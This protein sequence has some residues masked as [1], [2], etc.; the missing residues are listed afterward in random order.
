MARVKTFINNGPMFPSDLNEIQ[1]DY[2]QAFSNY[3]LLC[4]RHGLVCPT[5]SAAGGYLDRAYDSTL[6][7]ALAG[8]AHNATCLIYIDP[9]D[10]DLPDGAARTGK[11]RH[12]CRLIT[13]ANTP[14][15][16]TS[17]V[18]DL[19]PV[20]T[21]ATT[22][23]SGANRQPIIAT[24]GAAVAGS[25]LTFANPAADSRLVQTGGDFNVPSAGF[26]VLGWTFTGASAS[27]PVASAI[28][29]AE[30]QYRQV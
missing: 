19:R 8:E 28:A 16:A 30:L 4:E 21:W 14:L 15:A 17:V 1:D 24:L 23:T 7:I 13:N 3:R 27:S 29:I 12:R 9:A 2:D 26:Y 20:A 22:A 6:P 5:A 18:F 25:V 11:L 10:L